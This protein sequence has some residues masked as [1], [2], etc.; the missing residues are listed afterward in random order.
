MLCGLL[1]N[2][3]AGNEQDQVL[4]AVV[5]GV[6]TVEPPVIRTVSKVGRDTA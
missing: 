6:L 1:P 4:S 5:I 3:Q 2:P